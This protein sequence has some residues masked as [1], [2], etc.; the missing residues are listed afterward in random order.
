MI[1][2][3]TCPEC[4][5]NKLE[6]ADAGIKTFVCQTCAYV[7]PVTEKKLKSRADENDRD[8]AEDDDFEDGDLDLEL[9]GESA[10]GKDELPVML[11]KAKIK[12]KAKTAKRGKKR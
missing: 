11:K 1:T 9:D 10:I 6:L 12:T 7:G 4:G 2:E 3:Q 8:D 5:S